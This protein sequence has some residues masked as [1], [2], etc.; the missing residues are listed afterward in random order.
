ML[1]ITPEIN[2]YKKLSNSIVKHEKTV[3]K[4]IDD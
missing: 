3:L 4:Y 2:G 1:R